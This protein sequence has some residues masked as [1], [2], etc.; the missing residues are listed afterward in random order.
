[1]RRR[2]KNNLIN[3]TKYK[4]PKNNQRRPQLEADIAAGQQQP[5]KQLTPAQKEEIE[6][7]KKSQLKEDISDS[8]VKTDDIENEG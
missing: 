4:M 2:I 3:L 5:D 8:M 6:K 1:M 7:N